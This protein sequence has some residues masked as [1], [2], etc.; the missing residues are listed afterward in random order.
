MKIQVIQDGKGND[1]GVFIPIDDWIRIKQSYPD[2]ESMDIDLP[3][4]EKDL[5]DER[6]EA[7]NRDE[8]R[9]KPGFELFEELK[10]KS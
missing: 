6:L 4:W 10:R 7:I 3:Q 9:L 1:T 2:I 5:I 8:K